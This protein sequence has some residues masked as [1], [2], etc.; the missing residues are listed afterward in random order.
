MSTITVK[1]D[2]EATLLFSIFKQGGAGIPFYADWI[3]GG[4][5]QSM[6]I[7]NFSR[8]GVGVQAQNGGVWISDPRN[9]PSFKA[10]KTCTFTITKT[11]S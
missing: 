11:K 5:S 1:N 7:G 2:S 3:K 10:G 6:K 4:S 9:G 8:V